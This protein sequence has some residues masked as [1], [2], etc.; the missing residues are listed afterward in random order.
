MTLQDVADLAKVRRP[1][2]SMWRKRPMVRGVSLPFPDP[3]G[4]VNGIA[5]FDRAEIVDWLTRTGRG[6][7][8]EHDYDALTIAVPDGAD[9]EDVVTL[10]CWHVLT[11]GD[12]GGTSLEERIRGAN[13]F[14]PDDAVLASEIRQLRASE[15]VLA[16]VDDL[17]EASHGPGDALARVE[18]GRLKREMAL[19]EL[20]PEAVD[21]LRCIIEAAA[22]YLGNDDVVLRADGSSVALDVAEACDLDIATD[23][24]NVCRRALIR[25]VHV[26]EAPAGK[27]VSALSLV[28]LDVETTLKRLDEV[29][30]G[31]APGDIA[32]AIGTAGALA[33]ELAGELQNR[34]AYALRVDNLVAALRLP[35]GMWREAHRQ[36]LAVWV[37][38]GGAGAKIVS[39]ADL[40]AVDMIDL[41]DLAAD[42]AGALAQ[43]DVRA[44]RYAR[45][46]A[47]SMMRAR[48]PVVPR[49]VRA[50]KMGDDVTVARYLDDVHAATLVTTT[51][52]VPLDVL[53]QP[54]HA[55]LRLQ[56]RSLGELHGHDHLAVKRGRR[57]NAE[58]ASPDGTVRV[59]PVDLVGP[60]ALDPFDAEVKYPRAAR[61][62]PGDV[63]F[64]EKPRARA[65][66]DPVGGAMVASPARIIRLF[67]S[68]AVGPLLLATIINERVTPGTEWKDWSVPVLA[69]DEAE[70]LESALRETVEYEHQT[71]RRGQAA[72]DLKSALIDGVAAGALT[73]DAEPT[74]RGITAG[75]K[76][77]GRS[78]AST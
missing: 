2:V 73:L 22:V 58:D 66:V 20:A 46:M 70:R 14:D 78:D 23:D 18:T 33:D 67:D 53:V 29:I 57:I 60:M 13:E 16:Y 26:R 72:R 9:L 6:N 30:V 64:V 55:N 51:P 31:L 68:A 74:T 69:R 63:I 34:R 1:V 71:H 37:C 76:K 77:K 56:H 8:R 17:I 15:E 40:G 61:T 25:G 19:R 54:A 65:W 4:T 59:L 44:Y 47:S 28:G 41:S 11:G 43:T 52:L 48:G 36:A 12:L 21:L 5:R 49:G 38:M 7:N 42:I 35:R 45:G 50:V 3:V 27:R 32:I 75:R 39:V 10:L 24:R 62:E